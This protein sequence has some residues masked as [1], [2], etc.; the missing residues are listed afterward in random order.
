MKPFSPGQSGSSEAEGQGG[1][2]HVALVDLLEEVI[3]H[4]V[5]HV[6]AD[7][8]L[9]EGVLPSGLKRRRGDGVGTGELALA[10]LQ[11]EVH[12]LAALEHGDVSVQRLEA[13]GAGAGRGLADG[14]HLHLHLVRVQ[15]ISQLPDGILG[16]GDGRALGEILRSQLGHTGGPADVLQKAFDFNAHFFWAS[17]FFS[18]SSFTPLA[19]ARPLVIWGPMPSPDMPWAPA[20]SRPS[21]K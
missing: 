20:N 8:D 2:Q 21:I 5:G 1:L 17:F 19:A 6:P 14:D 15:L 18:M 9:K 10:D 7:G 12:I 3:G 16:I 13:V 11:A 4:Q